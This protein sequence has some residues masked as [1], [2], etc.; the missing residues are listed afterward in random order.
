M[1]ADAWSLSRTI[2][3]APTAAVPRYVDHYFGQPSS[4]VRCSVSPRSQSRTTGVT[5]IFTIRRHRCGVCVSRFAHEPSPSRLSS[6]VLRQR[7]HAALSAWQPVRTGPIPPA[8]V[9]LIL[10][11]SRSGHGLESSHPFQLEL[12]RPSKIVASRRSNGH[13]RASG[14]L[15]LLERRNN[16]NIIK[17]PI[18]SHHSTKAFRSSAALDDRNGPLRVHSLC[19]HWVESL[20]SF[21]CLPPFGPGRD[22]ARRRSLRSASRPQAHR[23][24][25]RRGHDLDRTLGVRAPPEPSAVNPR[26]ARCWS[27]RPAGR[28][29]GRAYQ[30]P[31]L[32]TP[33]GRLSRI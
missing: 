12:V 10:A 27:M 9:C 29:S 24:R 26:I 16:T 21:P 13:P 2:N 30:T 23:F 1:N 17:R 19:I 6:A 15:A 5:R 25:R 31:E 8:L 18:L 22:V 11:P 32:H 3:D 14:G 33:A 7:L 20:P 28:S 4:G